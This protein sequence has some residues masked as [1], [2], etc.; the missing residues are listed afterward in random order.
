[1][2]KDDGEDGVIEE[3]G[4][5]ECITQALVII[6]IIRRRR[7][8]RRR[9]HPSSSLSLTPKLLI[10]P[11]FTTEQSPQSVMCFDFKKSVFLLVFFDAVAASLK[12]SNKV[13][14]KLISNMEINGQI[15]KNKK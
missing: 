3:M 15:N 5:Y 10:S 11:L 1:M 13:K 2:M 12:N 14:K 6:T 7:R 9:R 8:H 4:F